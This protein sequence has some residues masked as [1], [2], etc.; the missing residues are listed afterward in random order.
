[1]GALCDL[2]GGKA[3]IATNAMLLVDHQIAGLQLAESGPGKTL[4]ALFLITSQTGPSCTENLVFTDHI[5]AQLRPGKT[6]GQ[7]IE[8]NGES[9]ALLHFMPTLHH[10]VHNNIIIAEN[11]LQ[12]VGLLQGAARHHHL[13]T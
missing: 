5:K 8:A 1:M 10:P 4:T 2:H 11:F 3:H 13:C 12:S 7:T 9:A 6:P